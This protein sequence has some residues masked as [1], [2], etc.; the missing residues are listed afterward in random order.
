MY[1]VCINLLTS[2]ALIPFTFQLEILK[3]H[4]LKETCYYL[5][6]NLAACPN[7]S[8]HEDL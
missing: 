7:Y 1:F 5:V 2:R 3:F 8:V 6:S 4:F